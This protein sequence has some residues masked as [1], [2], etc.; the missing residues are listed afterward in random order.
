MSLTRFS[1]ERQLDQAEIALGS[2]ISA[3]DAQGV[4]ESARRRDPKWRQLSADCR[5]LKSRLR[6]VKVTE[7]REV[8]CEKRKSEKA[9]A[10]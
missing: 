4:E 10:E 9:P 5:Q 7:E 2:R 6:A 1:I 8:E 3:L